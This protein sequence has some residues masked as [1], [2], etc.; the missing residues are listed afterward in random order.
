MAIFIK[1]HKLFTFSLCA[2]SAERS[3]KAAEVA[4]CHFLLYS[5]LQWHSVGR[6]A[7]YKSEA[8]FQQQFHVAHAASH[9]PY[10]HA[11]LLPTRSYGL[12]AELWSQ[13]A[14]LF[15]TDTQ[16]RVCPDGPTARADLVL[17]R[18]P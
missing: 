4:A 14:C 7:F 3:G 2:V 15:K 8:G 18:E 17:M 6:D 11:R 5:L 1:Y 12:E 9:K 10:G 16:Y 13:D